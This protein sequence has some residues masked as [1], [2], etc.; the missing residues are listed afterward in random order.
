MV[1]TLDDYNQLLA[2]RK[3][4]E[5]L[6]HIFN[7]TTVVF[8]GYGLGDQYVLDLLQNSAE[9]RSIFGTGPHFAVVPSTNN[10]LP[11]SI[12][13]LHYLPN[14]HKDH[15]SAIQII[16]EIK[17]T[18]YAVLIECVAPRESSNH[19]NL[20]SAHL[21]SDVLPPGTWSSSEVFT[22]EDGSTLF[23]GNGFTTAEL[24]FTDSTA[25]HDLIVGLLSFDT[26]YAPISALQRTHHLVG[27]ERF[28]DLIKS[29]CLRFVYWH[30]HEGISFR[31]SN[32]PTGGILTSF[33]SPGQTEQE[34]LR[35]LIR[36]HL[37]PV[38]GKEKEGELLFE[39]LEYKAEIISISVEPKIPDLVRGVLL[40]PSVRNLLGMSGGIVTTSI[41]RWMVYPTLRLTSVVKI[42]TA[43]Q[44]LGI[45]ST[46]L[47]Y[48]AAKLAAPAFAASSSNEWA[49]GMA[50]YALTGRFDTN[51]GAYAMQDPLIL[52]A[53]LRFRESQAGVAFR[54]EIFQQLSLRHGGDFVTSVNAGLNKVIPSRTLQAARDQLSGFLIA[55]GSI[56]ALPPGVW[57]NID[58][59]D[60]ALKLWRRTSAN[61]LK[62]YCRAHGITTY[63]LCPCGSGEKLR[64]CCEESLSQD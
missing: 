38:P 40:R 4:L 10:N 60:K 12:R 6:R 9:L 5:L 62:E 11:D 1:F 17:E 48:G 56:S 30:Q 36:R 27:P 35:E 49:D 46:K 22:L 44:I 32:S 55:E 8:V 54:K 42:G 53:I 19:T 37:S 15:R 64:F 31:E 61:A 25:M 20:K 47:E 43:C 21:L 26:V 50:S 13:P 33:G 52:V 57:N 41:P 63:D 16:E 3:Y 24:P 2:D 29:G 58:Y 23:T 28:W 14:P 34:R 59:A 18:R 45:A 7:E 51:L 39:L